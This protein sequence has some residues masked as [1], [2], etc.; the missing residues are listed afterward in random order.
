MTQ[1]VFKLLH[2]WHQVGT[3]SKIFYETSVTHFKI[4]AVNVFK[5]LKSV[6]FFHYLYI[7]MFSRHLTAHLK[8]INGDVNFAA[9]KFVNISPYRS[10]H[11][12]SVHIHFW[13]SLYPACDVNAEI[14]MRRSQR[15]KAKEMQETHKV[16]K[17]AAQK[18]FVYVVLKFS[19]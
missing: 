6:V 14:F 8:E 4:A 11:I 10:A 13:S 19:C 12:I 18:N 9:S 3:H 15:D 16:Q 5:T 1:N 2:L 7:L 17:S